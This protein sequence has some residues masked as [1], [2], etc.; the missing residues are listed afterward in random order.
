MQIAECFVLLAY[1]PV[2]TVK[3]Y[4]HNIFSILT[5]ILLIHINTCL[6]DRN[7]E[8]QTK[9]W[10]Y[11]MTSIFVAYFQMIHKYFTEMEYLAMFTLNTSG[12]FEDLFKPF[13]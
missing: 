6:L 4:V 10:G 13:Q 1:L 12:I 8:R 11:L 3:L 2:L 5:V 7:V 9:K